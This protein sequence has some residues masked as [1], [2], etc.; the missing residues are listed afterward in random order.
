MENLQLSEYNWLNKFGII[1]LDETSSK[2]FNNQETKKNLWVP[3]NYSTN[4]F[5]CE[6]KFSTLIVRQHHCRICG[7]IF[8]NN[9][10]SKQIH[11]SYKNKFFKIRI[12]NNCFNICENFS[13]YIDKKFIGDGLKETTF[14]N[15][16]EKLNINCIK[17]SK[18]ENM[19]KEKDIKNNISSLYELII[20]NLIRN[21]L[22]EYFSKSTVE[23]WEN[24]LFTLIKEVMDNLRTNSIFL[25]DSLNINKFIKIKIIPDKDISLCKVI[26]GFVMTNKIISKNLKTSFIGPK[27]LLINIENDSISKKLDDYSNLFQ[28]SNA[29]IKI[30]EK[31]IQILNPDIIL[32][33]KIYP[34]LLLNNIVNNSLINKK[35]Y[36]FDVKKKSLENIARCT[37]NIIFPSFDLLG[38]DNILGKCKNFY[39]KKINYNFKFQ[40]E[41]KVY[42]KKENDKNKSENY[43]IVFEGSNSLLF[44]T[45]I[46]AGEDKLFLK[47]IKNIMKNV[48]LPTIRD[49]FLQK[50]LFYTFNMKICDIKDINEKDIYNIFEENKNCRP[51]ELNQDSLTTKNYDLKNSIQLKNNNIKDV[52]LR[53]TCQIVNRLLSKDNKLQKRLSKKIFI[54]KYN[55]DISSNFFYKGFDLSIICK[56]CEF[57]N[58]S[59]IRISQTTKN[60][61]INQMIEN[62]LE[63]YDDE[64]EINYSLANKRM[65][66]NKI[67]KP[68]V[69]KNVHKNMGKYCKRPTKFFFSFFC[70]NKN[71]DKPLGRF[72]FELC[73]E[74]QN[75]CEICGLQL[76]SHIHHLYKSNGRIKVKLI[77]DKE[78]HLDTILKYLEVNEKFKILYKIENEN[79][80]DVDIYTYGYCNICKDITTPLFKLSNEVLNY[81]ISKFFRFFIENLN[82]EN[83]DREYDYNIKNLINPNKCNHFINK[84]ISRIFITKYGSWLFEY[85]SIKKYFISPLDINSKINDKENDKINEDS[86]DLLEEYRNEANINCKTVLDMLSNLFQK[87]MSG[88]EKLLNDEKLYLFKSNINLLINIIVL[89]IRLIEEFKSNVILKY[90]SKE[91]IAS[92]PNH[93]LLK[94]IVIIKKIYIK[95]VQIKII[96]NIIDNFIIEINVISGIL[97]KKMPISYEENV[98]LLEGKNEDIPFELQ[99]FD[100]KVDKT[101]TIN[102]DFE[103]NSTYLKLISF[104]EYYDNRHNNYSCEFI[105]HDMSCLVSTVL[106]SDDYLDFIKKENKNDIQ[107]SNIK[108][109]RTPN[110]LNYDIIK[111]HISSKTNNVSYINLYER[112]ERKELEEAEIKEKIKQNKTYFDDS[113]IFNLSKN[114]FYIIN[115]KDDNN[116]NN[117]KEILDFLEK[118]LNSNDSEDFNYIISNH[119][120]TFF[121]NIN[122]RNFKS[123]FKKEKE[124]KKVENEFNTNDIQEMNN[125]NE[126]MN[127]IKNKLLEFNNL[128]IEQQREL[129]TVIKSLLKPKVEK[130]KSSTGRK[131]SIFGSSKNLYNES[132]TGIIKRLSRKFSNSSKNSSSE[133]EY[134]AKSFEAQNDH[135]YKILNESN[136]NI[137][138]LS[139]VI[140]SFPFIPEFLKIFEL[141]KPKYYEEKILEKKYQEFK[142]KVYFPRQFEALRTT[143]CAT[144]EEFIESI[145][146]SLEWSVSGGKSKANFFKTYDNKYVI[147]NISEMEFNM[148]IESALNYFKH[149]SKYLFHK[150]SSAVGKILG[151]YNVKIKI[152]G[153]K[154]K[155]YYLIF[156]ENIYYGMLTNINN[157]TFNSPESNIMVYDLKGSK[158]NRYVQQQMKKPG[159]VLL[160]TN[161][162]DDFN[163]EPLFFDINVFQ[164]LQNALKNDSQFFKEQDVVDYSL[165]IIFEV[166]NNNISNNNNK[167]EIKEEKNYKLIRLGIIDYLRK[168]TWDKQLESYSKKF[169]NGFNNPTIINPESYSQRFMEKIQRYFAWI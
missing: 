52:D 96:A 145:R 99:L 83:N 169:I 159:K 59:L 29:Y 134:E 71:F 45:I 3:N 90:F 81:S 23:E 104:I 103:N 156:M 138:S 48:L 74:A 135:L 6:V 154:E 161:F 26:P 72:I 128:F 84:D 1:K 86:S 13:N 68:V 85:N 108:C 60:N 58:Y 144:N 105:N 19:E 17:F 139:S 101:P 16:Y 62:G 75:N 164:I 27:I 11:I 158:I 9:C 36:I 141:K 140:P 111:N 80:T 28:R 77:S 10:S 121:D 116:N 34:K 88:L 33:G 57:I 133:D 97:N 49:L 51:K 50:E 125:T 69:E 142:I 91:Y 152:Q 166:D 46:L 82:I 151:A 100:I 106:S 31:K 146:K 67:R 76:N 162:L 165:L 21:I 89:G 167:N 131:D 4:C 132:D 30:I 54:S 65:T 136:H 78:N 113:L 126:E 39:I 130:R 120:S 44:N 163:G 102:I 7:N 79:D 122:Y 115:N 5:D 143:F 20:K 114:N 148:F 157:Y 112:K 42:N 56:K 109:H 137:P 14:C 123:S 25:N 66:M 129:N 61:D 118:E 94:Y 64:Y 150:K 124:E 43:I 93:H 95:I 2:Y 92:I 38:T 63:Y 40:K 55:Q 117:E 98:N 41:S 24:I 73:K 70:D 18:F 110:A 22:D 32:V 119:F 8:C 87:Q 47:K 160:D 155:N 127:N 15:N 53:K 35:C 37:Q 107:F 149:I 12:C 168:Y 153:E 147:K